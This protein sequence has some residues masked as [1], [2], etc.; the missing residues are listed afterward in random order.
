M[1]EYAGT[2]LINCSIGLMVGYDHNLHE[3]QYLKMAIFL[4]LF[5]AQRCRVMHTCKGVGKVTP[6]VSVASLIEPSNPATLQP[7]NMY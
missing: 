5:F 4:N 3:S 7:F 2:V 6:L 1:G